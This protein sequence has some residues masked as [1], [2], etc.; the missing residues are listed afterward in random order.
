MV[1]ITS[2]VQHCT[3]LTCFCTGICIMS[4]HFSEPFNTMFHKRHKKTLTASNDI[5][6]N[7]TK[8]NSIAKRCFN[9][10]DFFHK[11]RQ[12]LDAKVSEATYVQ[13]QIIR[14]TVKFF[15]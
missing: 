6:E 8:N 15:I 11:K 12:N 4:D 3:E 14:I 1:S 5:T 2:F 13:C 7:K 9:Q 10:N